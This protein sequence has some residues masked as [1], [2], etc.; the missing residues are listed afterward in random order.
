MKKVRAKKSSQQFWDKEYKNAGNLS[1]S[2]NPSE[3]LEKFTRF[4]ERTSGRKHLNPLASVLD[5]GCGNGRNLIFLHDSFGMRGVGYDISHEAI[6]Q[7]KA[8]SHGK[9]ITYDVRSIAG[10]VA[11][12]S[13]SQTL[14]VDMMASHFLSR[15]ERE[16][17]VLEIARVLKYG[18]WFFYKT[19]LRNGDRNAERM[20]RDYP[21]DEEGTYVHPTIG[22]REHVST[23]EEVLALLEPHFTVRKTY[24]S[25]GH[26]GKQAKRRS[27]SVYAEKL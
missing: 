15:S 19:F 6:K 10:A 23:E 12:P 26:L 25:H 22:V 21:T 3:D 18:G 5:L 20:L 27:I 24:A 11:L 8:A 9:S 17:L 13:E 4:L 1:L 16:A 7:A 2:M 14:V